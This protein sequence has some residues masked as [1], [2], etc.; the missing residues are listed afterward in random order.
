[1]AA[2]TVEQ[3]HVRASEGGPVEH[4]AEIEAQAGLGLCGE[5]HFGRDRDDVT[6]IEAERVE[7]L[8][9]E[10]GVEL[11]PA[12]TWR[13][14]TT[15]G[16]DLG[17]LIGRRFRLGTAVCEGV[18]RCEPCAKLARRTDRRVLRGLLHSGLSARI[19]E[20]GTIRVGDAVEALP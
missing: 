11:Q 4:L 16:L 3:I 8:A 19:V 20:G 1:M 6:L 17:E 14:V 2:G 13:N 10:H 5:Y 15:R 12:E 9:A 7:R 18:E